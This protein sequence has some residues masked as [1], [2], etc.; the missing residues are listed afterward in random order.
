MIDTYDGRFPSSH[1]N[2]FSRSKDNADGEQ[3]ERRLFYVGI[4][5][6]KN[7]L[8]IMQMSDRRSSYISELFP[9]LD[10]H[11]SLTPQSTPRIMVNTVNLHRPTPPKKTMEEIRAEQEKARLA[12]QKS[13]EEMKRREYEVCYD[14]VRNKFTQQNE[15]IRDHTGRRWVKCEKCGEIKP[16]SE[17]SSYGGIGRVNL[18]TC[19][20]CSRGGH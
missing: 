6:A 15:Q 3:E 1:P 4:T 8:F 13:L 14:E 9:E 7:R 20:K 2:I 18:G 10:S 11:K 16:D 17:F 19:A 5:R 12:K